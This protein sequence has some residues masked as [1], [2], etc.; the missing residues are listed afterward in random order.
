[1]GSKIAG[2][3]TTPSDGHIASF[4][5]QRRACVDH[6]RAFASLD[7]A[8]LYSSLVLERWQTDDVIGR[9][10]LH[11]A[12]VVAYC[13]PFTGATTRSS[14]KR[15]YPTK[16]LRGFG[17]FDA[18]LHDHLLELRNRLIA[19][20]DY[21]VLPSTMYM[22][23]LGDEKLP[24]MLG[25]NVKRLIG[26]DDRN[27]GERYHSHMAVCAAGVKELFLE[28]YAALSQQV[29][30]RPNLFHSTQ[31]IP[32]TE[33]ELPATGG[34]LDKLPGPVG[35]A[36]TVSEPDFPDGMSG[37]RYQM[38]THQRPLIEGGKYTVSVKGVPTEH[39]LEIRK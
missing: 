38:I 4:E 1:V 35:D 28:A 25:I 26:I 27:L 13:R 8:E 33:I 9:S 7:M 18:R 10:A 21:G 29:R 5:R 36:S 31:S 16:H 20:S 39:I 6:F 19:H 11:A 22:Q 15:H 32:T 12:S 14:G 23:T 30:D 24:L 2:E 37:Y 17:G 3:M 34:K